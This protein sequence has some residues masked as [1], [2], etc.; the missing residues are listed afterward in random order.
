MN[1][2]IATEF[3]LFFQ[4][5]SGILQRKS[6]ETGECLNEIPGPKK[7]NRYVFALLAH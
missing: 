6:A 3:W 5:W 2:E 4:S 7:A 1:P